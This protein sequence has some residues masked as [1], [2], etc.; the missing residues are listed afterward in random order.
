MM[1]TDSQ[2]AVNE[3]MQ[4]RVA[5]FIV[6]ERLRSRSLDPG[7]N[8]INKEIEDHKGRVINGFLIWL[9]VGLVGG[10]RFYFKSYPSA[11]LQLFLFIASII[12]FTGL[13]EIGFM[14]HMM[15]IIICF[16]LWAKD[17]TLIHHL[18]GNIRFELEK[19]GG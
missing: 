4:A 13:I 17:L 9:T 12:P 15:A 6:Q 7:I 14:N 10:H 8:K 3:D 19:V 11:F 5:N 2:K 18:N 1:D 16:G